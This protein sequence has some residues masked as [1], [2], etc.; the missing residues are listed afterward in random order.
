MKITDEELQ[1]LEELRHYGTPLDGTV[2]REARAARRGLKLT[3]T[4]NPV[5][6]SLYAK[7]SGGMGVMASVAI[8]N[9]SNR[10]IPI[11]AVRLE[12]P[13]LDADFHWLRRL[14]EKEV[15]E[16]GG[17]VLPASGPAGFDPQWS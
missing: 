2:L 10:I 7:A 16:Y 11:R 6:N 15:R 3:Q 14:T 9:V 12:M 8:E 1:L 17:Y 4:G 13:G 5:E